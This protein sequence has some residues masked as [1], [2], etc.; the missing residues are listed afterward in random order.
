[1]IRFDSNTRLL[2]IC[3]CF[4]R[5]GERAVM[6]EGGINIWMVEKCTFWIVQRDWRV[7]WRR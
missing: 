4:E 1:M 5:L 7:K 2:G 6:D 3:G